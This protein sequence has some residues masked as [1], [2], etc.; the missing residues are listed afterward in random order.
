VAAGVVVVIVI[1]MA[2]LIKSC[3][4]S[5]TTS[6]LKNYNASVYQ[7]ITGSTSNA[8]NVL[9]ENG[10]AGG[11]LTGITQVL[12]TAESNARNDVTKAEN[13]HAP[14]QMAAAQ[15]SLVTVM[16]LRQQG[17]LTI[18]NYTPEAANKHTS[19]DAVYEISLGTSLLY[20]S[21]VVYKT[22]VAPNIAK[23]LNAAGLTAGTAAGDQQI[24][25]A[26][27]VPDLGWLNPTWIADTIGAK[28]ST[29]QANA[30]NDQPNLIHGDQ[31]NFTTVD[32]QQLT[33]G[34]SYTIPA[35]D[36]QTWALNVTD[37]GQ[38]AENAVG[39]SIK[40]QDVSDTGTATIPTLAANGGTNTCTVTLPSKPETGPYTVTAT[41]AT[42]PGEKNTQNNSQ[43]YTI[44]FSS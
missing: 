6:A 21:D 14:S 36:A 31:L 28:L 27:V 7:L 17:L 24:N 34:G 33:Q 11:N 20:S 2:L 5:A 35:A 4:S 38:T 18:A 13:L 29:T 9:G 44:T 19:K 37:G 40:I 15:S 26:Q 16:T 1:A 25:A 43:T 3:D 41:V 8:S 10:L 42:V 22:L 30:N 32:G 23:A 12:A 39:C